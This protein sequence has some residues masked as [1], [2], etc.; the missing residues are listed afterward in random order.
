MYTHI[1]T[2]TISCKDKHAT[3]AKHKRQPKMT[4]VQ[5][6]EATN[7]NEQIAFNENLS[8]NLRGKAVNLEEWVKAVKRAEEESFSFKERTERKGWVTEEIQEQFER[9]KILINEYKWEDV[10]SITKDI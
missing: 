4:T 5:Q 7:E 3:A 8:R 9:R 10:Q 6:R 2:S 1:H